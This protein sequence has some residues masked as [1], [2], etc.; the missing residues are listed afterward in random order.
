MQHLQYC[1]GAMALRLRITPYFGASDLVRLRLIQPRYAL[2][3][4]S[5][6][7]RRKA[8]TEVSAEW[9]DLSLRRRRETYERRECGRQAA[10]R[11]A[12]HTHL[13][14]LSVA[15]PSIGVGTVRCVRRVWWATRSL[16]I[17]LRIVRG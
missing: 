2:E 3:Q 16:V 15:S 1:R 17:G 4:Q 6:V 7:V 14:Y 8:R 13:L 11:P 5:I 12:L 10:W 9:H